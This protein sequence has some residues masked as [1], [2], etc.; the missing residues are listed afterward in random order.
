MERLAYPMLPPLPVG[1]AAAIVAI[2]Q[3]LDGR[4]RR[5]VALLALTLAVAQII[6]EVAKDGPWS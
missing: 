3:R 6:Y 4:A 2:A 1:A 5:N